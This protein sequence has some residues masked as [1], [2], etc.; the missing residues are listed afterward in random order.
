MHNGDL[1]YQTLSRELSGSR[2]NGR[3]GGIA[4]RGEGSPSITPTRHEQDT[5]A[6]YFQGATFTK[7]DEEPNLDA[8]PPS[9]PLSPK[10][11]VPPK[12]PT[13]H[14]AERKRGHVRHR[15]SLKRRSSWN[16]N[17]K[18][19]FLR[20]ASIDSI[21][22][23]FKD[24]IWL[25]SE[26][27]LTQ[28][29]ESDQDNHNTCPICREQL[30]SKINKPEF[31]EGARDIVG[32]HYTM[33]HQ[34]QTWRPAKTFVKN[35]WRAMYRLY[36]RDQ[37]IYDSDIEEHINARMVP[38]FYIFSDHWPG[39]REEARRM[40]REHYRNGSYV[41]LIGMQLRFYLYNVESVL[42]WQIEDEES[43]HEVSGD[44]P[45]DDEASHVEDDDDDMSMADSTE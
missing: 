26:Q 35:M 30:F 34:I 19:E 18:Q 33:A 28:W 31:V 25:E 10:T 17:L 45:S 23:P 39:I 14:L 24:T 21:I 43:E 12:A 15:T 20:R 36:E 2:P 32:P 27:C 44:E 42:E 13:R 16:P 9:P 6:S 37:V 7:E 1:V 40:V 29:I 3:R 8:Y 41:P 5:E 38:G 22:A 11:T 4:K